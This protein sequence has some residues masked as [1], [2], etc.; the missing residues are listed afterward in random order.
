MKEYIQYFIIFH[1]TYSPISDKLVSF[2]LF[3]DIIYYIFLS[4][5]RLEGLFF[6]I[7]I[8]ILDGFSMLFD[9]LKL[10]Y[11]FII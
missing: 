7:F 8:V 6:F 2:Q 4:L 1:I 10:F 5:S 11:G 9:I 3:K